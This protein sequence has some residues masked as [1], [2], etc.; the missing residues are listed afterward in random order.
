LFYYSPNFSFESFIP[1]DELANGALP[2]NENTTRRISRRNDKN[3]NQQTK[4]S[5]ERVN[6]YAE[7]RDRISHQPSNKINRKQQQFNTNHHI[8][9]TNHMINTRSK[10][11]SLSIFELF[12]FFSST[13][14]SFSIYFILSTTTIN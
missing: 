7:P 1:T 8:Q 11:F 3:P 4:P 9:P 5:F 13:N 6:H 10:L 12:F 14:L 2:S